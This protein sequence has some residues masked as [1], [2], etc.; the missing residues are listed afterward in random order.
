MDQ[1]GSIGA[2]RKKHSKEDANKKEWAEMVGNLGVEYMADRVSI[3][4]SRFLANLQRSQ[5]QAPQEG[6]AQFKALTA[7]PSYLISNSHATLFF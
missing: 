4:E 3:D 2:G 6:P 5:G 1:I 7:N